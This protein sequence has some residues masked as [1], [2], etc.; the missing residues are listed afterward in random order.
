MDVSDG[1]VGD[2]AHICHAGGVGAEID[3]AAV[4]LSSAARHLTRS[5]P[6]LLLA[7]LTGGDDYEIL[8]TIPPEKAD[9]FRRSAEEAGV[10]VTRI[11]RVTKGPGEPVLL[12]C[13]GRTIAMDRRS[14]QHFGG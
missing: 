6:Q 9:A 7:A 3:A 12:D 10:P 4:P 11:G 1:L 2:L 13:G 14:F 5:D 8:V